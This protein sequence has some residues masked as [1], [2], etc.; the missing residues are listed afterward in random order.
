MRREVINAAIAEIRSDPDPARKAQKLASLCTAAFRERG[1]ELVVVGGSAI[2]F[3]TE[4]AY[5][6]GDVD[7]CVWKPERPIPLR[8]RQEV[9]AELGAE[10]GPRSWEVA[11]LFVDLLGVVE[12]E[13]RTPL[14]Q[15]QAPFGMVN[16]IDPEELL[17]ERVLVSVYPSTNA[18]A[19]SR[20]IG[21]RFDVWP[22]RATIRCLTKC[23]DWCKRSA[24]NSKCPVPTIPLDR[25]ISW[26]DWLAGR[27]YRRQLSERVAPLGSQRPRSSSDRRLRRRFDGQRGL[28]FRPTDE[29]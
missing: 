20:W 26:E 6:S 24:V 14:R 5:L 9:M 8:L 4:G 15:L 29:L 19:R 23:S 28:P 25:P 18:A 11:G 27:K 7:L 2:E 12:K 1:I 10:G 3:Y 13:A 16:L 22:N 21:R 17:V